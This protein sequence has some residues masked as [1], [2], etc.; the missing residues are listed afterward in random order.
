MQKKDRQADRISLYF[1]SESEFL[2]IS[3][4]NV[5]NCRAGWPT[6]EAER[7]SR[8]VLGTIKIQVGVFC[9]FSKEIP[10]FWKSPTTFLYLAVLTFFLVPRTKG[11]KDGEDDVRVFFR[12]PHNV[13]GRDRLLCF[14]GEHTVIYLVTTA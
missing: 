10:C 9:L 3:S 7:E 8:R 6:P 14:V 13:R 11:L 4:Q 2:R 5:R 1:E 12:D